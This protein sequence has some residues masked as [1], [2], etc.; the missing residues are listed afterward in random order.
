MPPKRPV[1]V[2]VLAAVDLAA[3]VLGAILGG[4]LALVFLIGRG[5]LWGAGF[6]AFVISVAVLTV[7]NNG[8]LFAAGLG[9]AFGRRWGRRLALVHGWC[10]VFQAGGL[11]VAGGAW[12]AFVADASVRG[13]LLAFVALV[14]VTVSASLLPVA[15][16]VVCHSPIVRNYFASGGD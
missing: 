13:V 4:M 2:P 7:L 10:G 11:L 12:I 6:Q 5:D 8:L 9:L 14:V 16:V 1:A 3:S 15:Q